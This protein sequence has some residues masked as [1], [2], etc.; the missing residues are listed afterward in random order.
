M[1]IGSRSVSSSLSNVSVQKAITTLGSGFLAH[2]A[3]TLLRQKLRSGTL[4]V[5]DYYTQA[6]RFV[7]RLM[8]LFVA[9]DRGIL[10]RP[11]AA[12]AA[13]DRSITSYATAHL[14]RLA[15]QRAGT[16]RSNLYR[17]LW[18]V[19]E[20]LASDTDCPEPG[21]CSPGDL[22]FSS[23][24]MP[25]LAEC[26]LT[27]RELLKSVRFLAFTT[28]NAIRRAIDYKSLGAVE[29]GSIYESLLEMCPEI[30]ID[31][32]TF[33]LKFANG[34]VRKTSGSYYTPGS[35]IDCLL[36]SVL[37]PALTEAC[38]S[39]DPGQAILNLKVCDPACGS[40]LF[41]IATAYRI[42]KCLAAVRAGREEPGPKAYCAALRDVVSRC[43][44]GVDI[45]PMAV[46]LCR[47]NLW[48][49]AVEPGQPLF[50]LDAHIQCGNSL[51]GATPALLAR[52]I[53]G[54]SLQHQFFH[55][56]EAFPDVFRVPV[57]GEQPD[58]EQIG[59]SGGFDIVLGNPP[60]IF[61]ENLHPEVKQ[62]FPAVFSLARGQYDTCW[63]FIEASL[64]LVNAKGRC[65]LVVPDTLLARDETRYVRE[66]LLQ[67]GL[68]RLYY[69]G[70]AFKANVSTIIF[71][72]A[73]GGTAR[74][75]LCEEIDGVEIGAPVRYTCSKA[76]FWADPK[77]RFLT[78]LSDE[79]ALLLARVER[80][81][82]PLQNLVKISR[83][84]EIGK[85]DVLAQGPVPILVGEDIARYYVRQP[86]RFLQTIKKDARRYA[87]PKII[88][89]KTGYKCIAA[90]DTVGHVTMQSVYNLHITRPDIAYEALLAL[91]NSRFAH[92]FVYKIFTSYKGLFPQLN[93][94]T[95]QAIPVPLH[96]DS[97][98]DELVKLVQEM[99]DLKKA[100]TS[101]NFQSTQVEHVDREINRVIYALYGLTGAEIAI[102]EQGIQ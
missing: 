40:G 27:N 65:A 6:L 100:T 50:G 5:Q 74:E 61:G 62:L 37:E 1:Q 3:N 98:Q 19:M 81:C 80:V 101:K 39:S 73:K 53:P 55:W 94:S 64:K 21:L 32:A 47:V 52:G 26:N 30:N 78:H 46:E 28:E 45:N 2:P 31:A 72:V 34:N 44:Y 60:Y 15:G 20:K 9:E 63:L 58:N 33:E 96:I 90:L 59:R 14:R 92:W 82:T 89:L 49:E 84:E 8:A 17:D 24:T 85:K 68:E 70:T 87:S 56:H 76:R 83:G 99:V 12:Q 13:R 86:T 25:D 95:I 69:C 16:N 22:F 93:Q 29:L 38:A 10:F 97:R 54:G 88:M 91:L 4:C 11:Q 57:D 48:L 71:V 79:E 42:A 7:Y 67:E 18:L 41:L 35:L 23:T 43:I 66:L 102:I 75:I 77:R 36:D 51:L